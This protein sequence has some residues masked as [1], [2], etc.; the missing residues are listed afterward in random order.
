MAGSKTR[1]GFFAD[2]EEPPDE[3]EQRSGR[4]VI[5]H[6]I[7][8]QIPPHGVPTTTMSEEITKP[9]PTE[10]RHRPRQSRLVRMLGHWTESG[11]FETDDGMSN[12]GYKP[13]KARH[14]TAG[15]NVLLFVIVAVLTFLI[16]IA[17]VKLRQRYAS[18][19]PASNH[20]VLAET[21]DRPKVARLPIA[22]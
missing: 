19:G 14:S 10:Q 5:G 11:R 15:R 6:D 16:T 17:F 21:A 13:L 12:L 3:D 4:T 8:A 1:F 20:L 18:T 7:D 22:L 2:G 9:I